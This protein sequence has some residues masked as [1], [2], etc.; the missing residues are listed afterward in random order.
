[1]QTSSRP[2]DP[3]DYLTGGLDE[4]GRSFT[5][6]RHE[7]TLHALETPEDEHERPNGQRADREEDRRGDA[8][9]EPGLVATLLHA[10]HRDP[11]E[12]IVEDDVPC[13]GQHGGRRET[14]QQHGYEPDG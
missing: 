9:R 5:R 7:R 11:K 13:H 8:A 12:R 4:L 1:L 10:L 3:A 2:D 6:F 14:E